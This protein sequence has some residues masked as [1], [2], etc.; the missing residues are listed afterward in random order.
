MPTLSEAD[1][2]LLL[3]EHGVPIA[4][5]RIVD[6]AEAAASAADDVGYPVVVKLNGDQIAHKT[7]RGLV[8]LGLTS[9]A[10]VRAAGAD[11]LGAATPDDG[12][13][14]LLVAPMIRG[15]RELIVGLLDDPVFGPTVMLGLG[16]I[17]AEAVADVVFRPAPV[18]ADD[19]AEMIA[20]LRTAALLD[21]FRGEAAVD[22]QQLAD[23]LIGL[24]ELAEV[25][26]DVRSVDLNPL[27]VQA[28]GR[29]VAVDALVET[30][31]PRAATTVTR[32]RPND[33]AF[34]ALFEPRGV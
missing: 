24:G 8:R 18:G 10:D 14:S 13:V 6:T 21:A 33:D 7:E 34:R 5:E 31:P 20:D 23:V 12:D 27:I 28:D 9:A 19:A 29:L 22:R 3:S 32:D 15:S 26:P 16:G 2:K 11:L 4:A 25:R 1:S 30:G 17:L